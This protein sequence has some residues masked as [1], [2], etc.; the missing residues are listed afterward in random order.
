LFLF[1]FIFFCL[2]ASSWI[3]VNRSQ[4][5]K[6]VGLGGVPYIYIDSYCIHIIVGFSPTLGSFGVKMLDLFRAGAATA[7]CAGAG[8]LDVQFL[9]GA[10]AKD[11]DTLW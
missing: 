6:K 3:Y 2:A 9:K 1:I 4:G 10:D 11:G 7:S 5:S 8:A